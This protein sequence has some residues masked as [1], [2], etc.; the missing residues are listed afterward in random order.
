MSS[1][2][3]MNV[4]WVPRFSSVMM[5][6][7]AERLEPQDVLYRAFEDFELFRRELLRRLEELERDARAESGAL[8]RGV[9]IGRVTSQEVGDP[10]RARTL[11][12]LH[13]RQHF[14]QNSHG[15]TY[16]EPHHPQGSRPLEN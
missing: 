8:E 13:L 6:S 4:R 11:L 3:G 12:G 16:V 7:Q 15:A 5:H 14:G 10:E 1:C 9:R 2:S